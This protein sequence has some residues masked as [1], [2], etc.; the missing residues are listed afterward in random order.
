VTG[1]HEGRSGPGRVMTLGKA[2]QHVKETGERAFYIVMD[3][4]NLSGLNA[5]L[6]HSGANEVFRDIA[7][8][9]RHELSKVAS[10]SSFFR[11]GGD[12]MSAFLI[13]TTPEAVLEGISAVQSGV[14][15]LG[16][17][18]E[19]HDTPHAKH[20]HNER[21]RGIGVHFG[22]CELAA[23]HETA[24]ALVFQ[25]A[26]SRLE[27]QKNSL[28]HTESNDSQP[29]DSISSQAVERRIR[30]LLA[31][32]ARDGVAAI[33]EEVVD[34]PLLLGALARA[35][36]EAELTNAANYLSYLELPYD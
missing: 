12:E 7:A 18:R 4:H 16:R 31:I 14:L 20:P 17:E 11:H 27:Q 10:E 34:C 15:M 1:F 36:H 21:L 30:R 22:I 28:A 25:E 35:C 8:I 19:L 9:I 6:T 33:V 3:L 29:R 26:D 5:R 13:H 32:C 2:I 23:Q 24:D